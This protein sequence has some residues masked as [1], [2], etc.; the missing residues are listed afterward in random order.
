MSRIGKMP[1]DLPKGVKIDWQEPVVKV[2][3]P[4]GTLSR[5]LHHAVTLKVDGPMVRVE[6]KVAGPEGWAIWGLTRTLVNNMVLGVSTGYSKSMEV[7]GVG[8]RVEQPEPR[9]LKL[10][11][12]F[13]NPVLF[14]LPEGIEAA[15]DPKINTKF[16]L[17]GADKE[18][19]GLTCARIRAYRRPEPYKGKGVKY[20]GE[21]IMRKVGKSGGKAG[22]K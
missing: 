20:E 17:S 4:K 8:W 13:S 11:L 10:S 15:V 19:L 22:G 18:L 5:T 14:P 12:G 7:V 6:P 21:T 9:I 1:I 2:T 3:G 16:S